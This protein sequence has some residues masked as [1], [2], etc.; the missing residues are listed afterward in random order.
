MDILCIQQNS[1]IIVQCTNIISDIRTKVIL[2][3]VRSSQLHRFH[4][5]FTKFMQLFIYLD[6][7]SLTFLPTSSQ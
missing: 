7:K 6:R 1:I 4:G 2:N 3:L 5:Y